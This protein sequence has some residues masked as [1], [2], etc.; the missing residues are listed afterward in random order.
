[1]ANESQNSAD[2]NNNQTEAADSAVFKPQAKDSDQT[3]D[4]STNTDTGADT[5]TD[6]ETDGA[7]GQIRASQKESTLGRV[8][9]YASDMA[10]GKLFDKKVK[11]IQERQAAKSGSGNTSGEGTSEAGVNSNSWRDQYKRGADARKRGENLKDAYRDERR[12]RRAPTGGGADI[13]GDTA[14]AA[15]KEAVTDTAKAVGTE[16]VKD[17]AKGVGKEVAKDGARIALEEGADV[18]PGLGLV[19]A[20]DYKGVKHTVQDTARELKDFHVLRAASRAV[21]GLGKSAA[22]TLFRASYDL[23]VI[24]FTLGLSLLVTFF[25]GNILLFVPDADIGPLEKL[26]IIGTD[27]FLF[28]LL[29]GIVVM[30]IYAYCKVDGSGQGVVGAASGIVGSVAGA[31]SNLFGGSSGGSGVCQAFSL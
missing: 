2:P 26:V 31:L 6:G 3:T 25:L 29:M 21:T 8:G 27:L 20:V 1:M 16:A 15:G 18:V 4:G 17:T 10:S 11:Q 12:I 23:W 7:L 28:F 24:G 19:T 13:A 5:E 30:L 22:V 14:R 9:D